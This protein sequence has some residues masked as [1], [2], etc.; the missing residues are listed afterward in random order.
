[1]PAKVDYNGACSLLVFPADALK[2]RL[3]SFSNRQSDPDS[4]WS[5]KICKGVALSLGG[6]LVTPQLPVVY[7]T[8]TF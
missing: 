8:A 3:I 6:L 1:M 7:N 2:A 4:P 5:W